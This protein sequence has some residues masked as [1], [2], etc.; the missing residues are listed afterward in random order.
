MRT[1]SVG[2]RRSP[3]RYYLKP[4]KVKLWKVEGDRL[5]LCRAIAAGV[6]LEPGALSLEEYPGLETC[7]FVASSVRK[8]QPKLGFVLLEGGNDAMPGIV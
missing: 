2:E 3:V 1:I 7:P 4:L 5:R 6:Y 8:L